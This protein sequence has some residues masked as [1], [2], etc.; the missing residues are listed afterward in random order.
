M[1]RIIGLLALAAALMLPATSFA[2]DKLPEGFTA[3]A[4]ETMNWADAK[5]WCEKQGGRLPRVS[6]KESLGQA[7][8]KKGTAIDVFGAVD[9]PWPKGLPS[10]SGVHYWTGTANADLPGLSMYVYNLAGIVRALS[11]GKHEELRRVVCVPK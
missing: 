2:A 5:A 11:I 7:E 10:G 6:G 1:K 4:E 3:L 9:S 8:V